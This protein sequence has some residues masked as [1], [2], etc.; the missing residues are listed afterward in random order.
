MKFIASKVL[1][2]LSAYA[3]R[4]RMKPLCFLLA[5]WAFKISHKP[6]TYDR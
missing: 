1:Y 5:G 3:W 2:K 6:K 4:L